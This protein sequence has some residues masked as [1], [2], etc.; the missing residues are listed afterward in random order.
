MAVQESG[1]RDLFPVPFNP[2][3]KGTSLVERLQFGVK[4]SLLIADQRKKAHGYIIDLDLLIA[5]ALLHNLGKVFEYRRQ[6]GRFKKTA[7]GKFFPM[8]FEARSWL[9]GK[10]SPGTRLTWSPVIPTS[11]P[12]PRSVRR[13]SFSTMPILMPSGSARGWRPFWKE[14]RNRM[15]QGS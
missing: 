10:G 9:C 11:P 1:E 12:F 6:G 2:E 4:A 8:A 15:G 5:S 7:I 13:E 3:V 14:G